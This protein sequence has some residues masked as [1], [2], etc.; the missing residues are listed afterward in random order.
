[1]ALAAICVE[2]EQLHQSTFAS[3]LLDLAG[4]LGIDLDDI[5]LCK[6]KLE[7]FLSESFLSTEALNENMQ[8]PPEIS[9]S[10]CAA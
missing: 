3:E 6:A 8:V 2:L 7:A 1:M 4:D 10:S 5:A 9:F